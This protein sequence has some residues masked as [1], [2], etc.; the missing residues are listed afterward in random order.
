MDM[1]AA[2]AP[3]EIDMVKKW[4]DIYKT[5]NKELAALKQ[6]AK[7]KEEASKAC[8]A[9]QQLAQ[10]IN[11]EMAEATEASDHAQD[12]F[13]KAVEES[14]Q[15]LRNICKPPENEGPSEQRQQLLAK[16]REV[17]S[18]Q[19]DVNE[20]LRALQTQR[21]GLLRQGGAVP[22]EVLSGTGAQLNQAMAAATQILKGCGVSETG[23][24]DA[25]PNSAGNLRSEPYS[26]EPNRE[27]A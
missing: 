18:T 21:I 8:S 2:A 12:K 15:Y 23:G 7:K 11:K 1:M 24:F 26:A 3:I 19:K 13:S 27:S 5:I 9:M 10:F 14:T 4:K 16:E 6:A 17:L 22:V 25:A 20:Q